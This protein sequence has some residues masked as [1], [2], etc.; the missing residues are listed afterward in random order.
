L[1]EKGWKIWRIDA[2]MTQ[3]D[4]AMTRFSQW[5]T[6]SVRSGYGCAQVT[7]LH[8]NSQFRLWKTAIPSAIFWGNL[9]PAAIV[10]S[11]LTHPFCFLLTLIYP[12]QACKIAVRTR[13]TSIVGWAY[14][15]FAVLAKFPQSQGIIRFYLR[16]SLGLTSELIEYKE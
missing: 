3:H 11:G 4:A 2:D 12:L 5:W 16:S 1:R 8:R 6:R 10:L 15:I 9:L 14:S 13:A 7:R